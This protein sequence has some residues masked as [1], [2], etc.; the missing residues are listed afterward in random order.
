MP[1]VGTKD[2]FLI[3]ENILQEIS[4]CL[5][6]LHGE[7]IVK[8][9]YLNADLNSTEHASVLINSFCNDNNLCCCDSLNS[10]R[11]ESN[12]TLI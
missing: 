10:N 3:I 2:R 6:C 7:T 9:G 11:I 1:C 4:D 5:A 12:Y 8:G